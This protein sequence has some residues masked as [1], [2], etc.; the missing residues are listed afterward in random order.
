MITPKGDKG[1]IL[2]KREIILYLPNKKQGEIFQLF[3]ENKKVPVKILRRKIGRRI[4]ET[5]KDQILTVNKYLREKGIIEP[6]KMYWTTEN[7]RE[8]KVIHK[9]ENVLLETRE[10]GLFITMNA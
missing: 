1:E 7:G 5:F 4:Y 3:K 10:K 2:P 6:F 8:H 9:Q